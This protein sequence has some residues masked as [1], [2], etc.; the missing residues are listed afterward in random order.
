MSVKK[1]ELLLKN[2][3]LILSKIYKFESNL[4]S[5]EF[6]KIE[7]IFFSPP[8]SAWLK[9]FHLSRLHKLKYKKMD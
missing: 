2:Q 5:K 8:K 9:M 7:N 3:K 4:S 1:I 6:E